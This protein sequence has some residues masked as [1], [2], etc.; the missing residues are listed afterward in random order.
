MAL[1]P[2]SELTFKSL[3]SR[4]GS[5]F[6]TL[7]L[8]ILRSVFFPTI[9]SVSS[10]PFVSPVLTVVTY[11]PLRRTAT[12]SEISIT[13]F[14]LW[15]MIIIALP[16]SRI[17]RRTSKSFSV[18]CGVKTAVGS[19]RIRISAPRY[20]T[21]SISTVCFS[22][23]DISYT[24]F[25]TSMLKPYLSAI[26]PTRELTSLILR[27]LLSFTPRIMFSAAVKMSTS[28]KCWWII[29]ILYLKAS[30]GELMKTF[31]PLMKISPSSGA[32]IPLMMFISVV[33][34]L[35]FSPKMASTSFL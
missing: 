33:F 22:E 17:L 26:A 16:S 4:R 19:S 9:I 34:P 14:N 18:S 32:Y 3:I 8:S 11:S 24:C 12:S 13:S 29:P 10:F 25:F 27:P 35:P 31:S 7:G 23:T 20:K 21:F 5:F 2:S 6:S 28:L 15:V 30:S 1:L